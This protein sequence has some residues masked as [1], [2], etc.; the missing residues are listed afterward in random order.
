[1]C[2]Q[3]TEHFRLQTSSHLHSECCS[4]SIRGQSQ[5][6]TAQPYLYL[7]SYQHVVYIHADVVLMF[8]SGIRLYLHTKFHVRKW[9]G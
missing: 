2:P 7:I 6:E 9:P 5:P 1:M 3:Y 4:E 8:C